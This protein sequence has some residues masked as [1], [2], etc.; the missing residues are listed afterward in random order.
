MLGR[1]VC[2]PLPTSKKTMIEVLNEK[3]FTAPWLWLV[4]PKKKDFGY[5]LGPYDLRVVT[6]RQQRKKVYATQIAMN[7]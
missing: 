6:L 7:N 2:L 3:D 1:F 5:N 4:H